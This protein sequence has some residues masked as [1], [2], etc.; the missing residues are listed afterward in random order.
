V[1]S[2]VVLFSIVCSAAL[3]LPQSGKPSTITD[4]LVQ[5]I[6]TSPADTNL[7]IAYRD[8]SFHLY[9]EHA[10]SAMDLAYKGLN[11]SKKLNFDYGEAANTE[12]IAIILM[13]AGNYARSLEFHLSALRIQERRKSIKGVMS[14]YNN[15]GIVNVYLKDFPQALSCYRTADSM[16]RTLNDLE[17]KHSTSLNIGDVFEDSGLLDSA[18]RYYNQ[19][20]QYAYELRNNYDVG[21]S[22]LGLANVYRMQQNP[23]P[24]IQNYQ[25]AL[26]ALQAEGDQEQICEVLLG[27]AKA[28]QLLHHSD[29]IFYYSRSSWT[30][31]NQFGYKSKSLDAAEFLSS[32]FAAH[33]QYDSAY[34]YTI[35][36]N[37]LKDSILSSD[38]LR[39]TQQLKFDERIYQQK[40]LEQQ[41]KEEAERWQHIQY[42]LISIFIIIMFLVTVLLSRI[43]L[44]ISVIKFFGVV[45]LLFLFEFLTLLLHPRV[46]EITHHTPLLEILIFVSIA[47]VLIPA[48][49]KIE[50]WV[51]ERLLQR[52]RQLANK[53]RNPKDDISEE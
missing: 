25:I 38:K 11:L 24:A 3:L 28:H 48:H 43:Q 7:V 10:D 47:A 49:H 36:A 5:V 32:Q 1:K 14:S 17:F 35:F 30:L 45:S 13:D 15:L 46:Q 41:A 4:S 23:V 9:K 29:S 16:N 26:A 21:L 12:M 37:T 22:V 6:K 53:E 34:H 19:S 39:T 40:K 44:R 33:H 42:I 2:F 20:L 52:R 8:L 18:L 50:H 51:I 31:A 27:L